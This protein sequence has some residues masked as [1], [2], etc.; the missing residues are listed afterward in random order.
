MTD[1]NFIDELTEAKKKFATK[2]ERVEYFNEVHR[3]I[4]HDRETRDALM[5]RY[6]SGELEIEEPPFGGNVPFMVGEKTQRTERQINGAPMS[7]GA[8]AYID[9]RVG[10]KLKDKEEEIPALPRP[11]SKEAIR[12]SFEKFGSRPRQTKTG[13]N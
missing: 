8:K 6:R 2:A 5:R 10:R 3:G 9:A 12:A 1:F 11:R 13:G 7:E 4:V